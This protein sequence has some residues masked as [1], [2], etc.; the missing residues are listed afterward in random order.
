MENLENKKLEHV[1]Y[2]ISLPENIENDLS[3]LISQYEM[4]ENKIL[5]NIVDFHFNFECIHPFADGNGRIGRILIFKE[6][7]RNNI[8]PFVI[9]DESKLDYYRGLKAYKEDKTIFYYILF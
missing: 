1:N 5:N 4:Y 6:C 3:N 7:L 2:E 9:L 8:T